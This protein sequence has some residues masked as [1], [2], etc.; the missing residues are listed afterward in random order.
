MSPDSSLSPFPFSTFHPQNFSGGSIQSK[1]SSN[2]TTMRLHFCLFS[3][4]FCLAHSS[5]L[6]VNLH[7]CSFIW[8]GWKGGECGTGVNWDKIVYFHF[9]H[10]VVKQYDDGFTMVEY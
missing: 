8:L 6:F 2:R 9:P 4:F 5:V 7:G 1:T 10:L 3:L